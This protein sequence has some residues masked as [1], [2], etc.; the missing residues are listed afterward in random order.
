MHFKEFAKFQK[1]FIEKDR[2]S[3]FLY[4]PNGDGANHIKM[5][6]DSQ[7]FSFNM[8]LKEILSQIQ[9]MDDCLEWAISLERD[10]IVLYSGFYNLF[11]KVLG[12]TEIDR[13]IATE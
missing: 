5:L 10:T 8:K 9:T 1:S 4:E 13:I 12:R 2:S 7:V 6:S 11:P 3:E